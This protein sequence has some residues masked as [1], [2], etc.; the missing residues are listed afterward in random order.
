M[1][2]EENKSSE[3]E[4]DIHLGVGNHLTIKSSYVIQLKDLLVL[5]DNEGNS[6][7]LDVEIKADLQNIPPKWHQTMIQMMSARYGGIVRCYDNSTK[8]FKSPPKENKN[9]W[10][11]ILNFKN[12]IVTRVKYLD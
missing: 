11:I 5:F 10:N 6:I 9:W 3:G 7:D 1:T 2:K 4:L 12:S 8:P